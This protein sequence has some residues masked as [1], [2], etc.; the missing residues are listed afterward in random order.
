MDGELRH[1]WQLKRNCSLTPSQA[2]TALA[3]LC[4][5]TF[6]VGM[7]FML[8]HGA[9]VIL[10]FSGVEMLAA[11][12]A[13]LCYAR[14]AT[15]GE[16]IAVADDC[17]LVEKVSAGSTRQLRLDP[18]VVRVSLPRSRRDMIVLEARG[19]R[20][21]IGRYVNESVRRQV[22]QELRRDLASRSLV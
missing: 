4:G 8:I 10:G 2:M 6:A 20:V 7:A 11:I 19:I 12:A 21:E 14:H 9:W 1:E 18:H 5:M 22:A 16:H 13:F 17:L 15:D 3:I